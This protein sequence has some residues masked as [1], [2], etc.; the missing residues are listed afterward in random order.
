MRR[1]ASPIPDELKQGRHARRQ[2]IAIGQ[3]AGGL[4]CTVLGALP[5]VRFFG[6]FVPPLN[7]LSW[8]GIGLTLLAIVGFVRGKLT[9]GPY[10]YVES[11]VPIVADVCSLVVRPA[12]FYNGQP[13][14][15]QIAALIQYRDPVSDQVMIGDAASNALSM[16]AKD[17]VTTSYHVGDY[18]TGTA[19]CFVTT[20]SSTNWPARKTSTRTIPT[21]QR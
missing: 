11:G 4:L 17:S 20:I 16:N 6:D 10:A 21:R 2:R 19:S 13:T 3:F 15:H 1:G 9:K 5:V 7:Y 14:G 8:I 12:T 18:A